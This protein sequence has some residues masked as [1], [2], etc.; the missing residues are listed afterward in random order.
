[1]IKTD[2]RQMPLPFFLKEASEMIA[3]SHFLFISADPNNVRLT[4]DWGVSI[5]LFLFL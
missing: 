3:S 2:M 5:K 4:D 1:M